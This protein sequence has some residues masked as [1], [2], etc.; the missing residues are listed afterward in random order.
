MLNKATEIGILISERIFIW[1]HISKTFMAIKLA[2]ASEATFITVLIKI[3]EVRRV[4]RQKVS[5]G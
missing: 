4:T 1:K 3:M 5:S 2:A